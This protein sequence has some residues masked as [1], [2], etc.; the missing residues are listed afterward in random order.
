MHTEDEARHKTCPLY[1]MALG[2]IKAVSIVK[3]SIVY[4]MDSVN[5]PLQGC[6]GS[7]CMMWQWDEDEH[8][9]CRQSGTGEPMRG[10]CGLARR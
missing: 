4:N 9:V 10:F 1:Q 8:G 2:Y 7:S 3:G 5:G 6:E